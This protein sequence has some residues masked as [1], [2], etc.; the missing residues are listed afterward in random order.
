MKLLY[1][2]S[3][4]ENFIKVYNYNGDKLNEINKYN[5]NFES[6]YSILF[7]GK[8]LDNKLEIDKFIRYHNLNKELYFISIKKEAYDD[9]FQD[10]KNF[11]YN[12]S[13]NKNGDKD[14]KELTEEIEKSQNTY[15]NYYLVE[16]N[17]NY[18]K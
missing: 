2:V 1:S 12:S 7:D 16:E 13:T 11:S 9:S 15:N 4:N 17:E 10:E 5:L 8:C 6:S 3:K 18:K 14:E